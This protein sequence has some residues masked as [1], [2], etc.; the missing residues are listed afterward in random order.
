M[1]PLTHGLLGAVAAKA[2]LGRRLGHAGWMIGAAAGML[3]DVDFFLHSDAD[4]LL[5]IEVHRQFTHSLAA[6]PVGGAIAALPW[7]TFQTFRV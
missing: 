7:L 1:D 2:V 3:P 6:I 5:N 4:P